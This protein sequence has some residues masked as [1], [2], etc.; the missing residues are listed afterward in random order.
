[1]ASQNTRIKNRTFQFC[2][3]IL[4]LTVPIPIRNIT[5][6]ITDMIHKAK[7]RTIN[8]YSRS[9]LIASIKELVTKREQTNF[10]INHKIPIIVDPVLSGR[11][12]QKDFTWNIM[13]IYR[14]IHWDWEQF[15]CWLGNC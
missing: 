4:S 5:E 1:M 15:H 7:N 6:K 10:P 13:G 9:S 12:P 3:K 11:H 2:V 8:E 14:I